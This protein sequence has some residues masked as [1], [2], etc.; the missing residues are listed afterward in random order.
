MHTAHLTVTAKQ[1]GTMSVLAVSGELDMVSSAGFAERMAKAADGLTR[2]LLVDLSGLAF[3]DCCGARALTAA[4]GA[5]SAT[6]S[7]TVSLCVRI[8][9]RVLDLLGLDLQHRPAA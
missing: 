1:D 4:L 2:P 6:E 7:V 8:V 9:Q 3:T 5:L